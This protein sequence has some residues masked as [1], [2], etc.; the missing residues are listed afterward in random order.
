MKYKN[1]IDWDSEFK[2]YQDKAQKYDLI[3]NLAKEENQC[4]KRIREIGQERAKVIGVTE[5]YKE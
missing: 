2:Q 1:G 3:V 4:R 5:K